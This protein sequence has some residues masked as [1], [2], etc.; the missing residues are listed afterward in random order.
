MFDSW[1]CLPTGNPH[2]AGFN[3]TRFHSHLQ[4]MVQVA[5]PQCLTLV[6]KLSQDT[7]S[8]GAGCA[9]GVPWHRGF[10]QFHVRVSR[11]TRSRA[12]TTADGH[13]A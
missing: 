9:D 6:P 10:G 7:L 5:V 1:A 2:T 13:L 8:L 12:W 3:S 4:N 11:G